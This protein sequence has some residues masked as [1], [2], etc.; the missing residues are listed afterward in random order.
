[1]M[2]ARD[3]ATLGTLLRHVIELLDGAVEE[4]YARAGLAYRPRYTPV[5]RALLALGPASIRAISR[6]A[7]I[8]HSAASQTVAQMA[9]RG[10]VRLR[11]GGDGRERIV[12]LTSKARAMAPALRRQWAAT[13]RAAS[14]LETE[15]RAPL[16]EVLRET[17]RALERRPFAARIEQAGRAEA[18]RARGGK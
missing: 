5:V 7:G 9:R 18:R 8:T 2:V 13:N 11:P 17:I 12:A 16:S 4:A 15:L 14:R 1:M 6:H 3:A 10:L